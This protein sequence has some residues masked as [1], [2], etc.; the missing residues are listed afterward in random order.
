MEPKAKTRENKE[1]EERD[2][3]AA[4]NVDEQVLPDAPR[5]G[6]E[7]LG[8]EDA[9]DE[10]VRAQRRARG[11]DEDEADAREGRVQRDLARDSVDDDSDGG[12]SGDAAGAGSFVHPSFLILFSRGPLPLLI[13][14]L[15][16][17]PIFLPY[18]GFGKC[19]GQLF[20]SPP[21]LRTGSDGRVLVRVFRD[22]GAA[23]AVGAQLLQQEQVR[24]RRPPD[25]PGPVAD[26]GEYAD[27]NN[28]IAA[29]AVV[30]VGQIDR[31]DAVGAAE[32][33]EGDVLE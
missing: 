15:L 22:D 24:G 28:V 23:G 1:E 19:S 18:L 27:D 17:L 33:E 20:P 32:R 6:V 12:G 5:N 7:V 13:P 4:Y 11:H 25:G 10:Q 14:V 9:P 30:C 16:L 3:G 8:R 29:D 2:K 26:K 21:Q 31:R